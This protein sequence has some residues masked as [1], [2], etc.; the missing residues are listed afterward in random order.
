MN[1]EI[2]SD[3]IEIARLHYHNGQGNTEKD[4]LKD[5]QMIRHIKYHIGKFINNGKYNLRLLLNHVTVFTNIFGRAAIPMII[6]KSRDEFIP[7]INAVAK[8]IGFN[9]PGKYDKQLYQEILNIIK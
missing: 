5:L 6:Y 9:S 3:F 1:I 7:Y 4:M 8:I 2:D